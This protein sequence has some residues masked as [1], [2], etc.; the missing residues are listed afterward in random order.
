[1][2]GVVVLLIAVFLLV[3]ISI[4]YHSIKGEKTVGNTLYVGGSGEENYSSIQDAINNAITG[5]TIYVYSGKYYENISINKSI[6]LIGQNTKDTIIYGQFDIIEIKANLTNISDFTIKWFL[7]ASDINRTGIG[8]K[9]L[10]ANN[11]NIK[12]NI[13]IDGQ[14]GI[15][16]S[17]SYNNNIENNTISNNSFAIFLSNQ[18]KNNT[19][20]HNNFINNTNNSYDT[21]NNTWFNSNLN[22]GNYWDDYIGLDKNNDGIGDTPYNIPGGGNI[23]EYPLI[24]PYEGKIRPGKFFVEEGP[25]YTMLIIGLIA[26]ILFCLPVGYICYRKYHKVK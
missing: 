26:A 25:L 14:Y 22:Q 12:N 17:N 6:T 21:G 4:I 2:R 9:F 8:I 20:T 5:S 3:G 19:I 18:C 16:L 23:D 1:M 24:M 10:G 15:Y 7:N 13:I 11:C